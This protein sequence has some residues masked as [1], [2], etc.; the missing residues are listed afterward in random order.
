[1]SEF[2]LPNKMERGAMFDRN[3]GAQNFV[4]AAELKDLNMPIACL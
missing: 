4:T 1:M 3:F 2:S